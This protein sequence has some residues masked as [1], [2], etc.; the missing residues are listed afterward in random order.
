MASGVDEAVARRVA[1]LV[2]R[3]EYKRRQGAPGV[4]LGLERWR[5]PITNGFAE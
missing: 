2:G 3:S 1:R 4:V 5:M